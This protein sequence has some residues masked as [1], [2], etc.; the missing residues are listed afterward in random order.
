QRN[1]IRLAARKRRKLV[2][3]VQDEVARRAGGQPG[4]GVRPNKMNRGAVEPDRLP[5][6][7]RRGSREVLPEA[8]TLEDDPLVAVHVD[9]G[10]IVL[11]RRDMQAW[12]RVHVQSVKVYE[13]ERGRLPYLSREHER[14]LFDL[15]VRGCAEDLPEVG[16]PVQ[17]DGP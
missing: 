5:G 8:G 4:R 13:N 14:D 11:P 9:R 6:H 7:V 10:G 17:A 12:R 2:R 15:R 16:C 1:G 3:L